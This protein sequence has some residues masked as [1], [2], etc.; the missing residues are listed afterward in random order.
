M[1]PDQRRESDL[2]S[3]R[4]P[5]GSSRHAPGAPRRDNRYFF[6][7]GHTVCRIPASCLFGDQG[8]GDTLRQDGGDRKC[9][10]WNQGRSEERRVGKEGVSTCR[11]RWSTYHEKKKKQRN[12]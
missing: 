7:S 1:A 6:H 8:R 11:T 9:G 4:L 12:I 10:I 5:G 2:A 3:C